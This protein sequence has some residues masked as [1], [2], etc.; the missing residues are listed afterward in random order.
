MTVGLTSAAWW[1]DY[2]LSMVLFFAG[3]YLIATA[4]ARG[5]A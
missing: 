4:I 1:Q 2:A 3:V 5:G